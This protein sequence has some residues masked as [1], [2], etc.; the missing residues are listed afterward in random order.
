MAGT[1]ADAFST[2]PA[3]NGTFLTDLQTFLREE[4]ALRF[5]DQFSGM[6][7]SGGLHATAGSLTSPAFATV[8]Y[9]G[10]FRISQASATITYAD[11]ETTWVIA[12][13]DAA[14]NV[15]TFTRVGTSHYL[16]DASSSSRP[17]LPA[18]AV[19]LMEVTTAGGA[20]TT[21]KDLREMAPRPPIINVLD[22]GAV[23]DWNGATGTDNTTGLQ[24]AINAAA[25]R[26][27]AQAPA[28]VYFAPGRYRVTASLT[29]KSHMVLWM[30]EASL[31]SGVDITFLANTATI[32]NIRVL[33]GTFRGVG[34]T[35][36]A[37][38][39]I[40]LGGTSGTTTPATRFTLKDLSIFQEDYGIWL[41]DSHHGTVENIY[42]EGV[43][44][45][46]GHAIIFAG[47]DHL[48]IKNVLAKDYKGNLIF[49]HRTTG[50]AQNAYITVEGI[51]G[52][53]LAGSVT[54]IGI[55]VRN[56]QYA[57][58]DQVVLD[59]P[60]VA[61]V[62][63]QAE[64][65][66]TVNLRDIVLSNVVMRNVQQRGVLVHS[67]NRAGA[68]AR[69]TLDTITIFQAGVAAAVPSVDIVQTVGGKL[70]N[71][72]INDTQGTHAIDIQNGSHE[73]QLTN[74]HIENVDQTGIRIGNTA[75]CNRLT[76]SGI[77][78][79]DASQDAHNTDND[80]QITGSSTDIVLDGFNLQA[81]ATNKARAGIQTVAGTSRITL[82][83]G[84]TQDHATQG[85]DRND[86]GAGAPY[87]MDT[88][89]VN[90]TGSTDE[91]TMKTLTLPA[92]VM[93]TNRGMRVTAFGTLTG[94]TDTKTIRLKLGT[95]TL[96]TV[97]AAAGSTADWSIAAVLL[98]NASAA[99]QRVFVK[100]YEG[101]TVEVVD[102]ATTTETNAS[103]LTMTLTGQLGNAA[104]T[105]SV[106]GWLVEPL[107]RFFGTIMP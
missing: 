32:D 3:A 72:V 6:V 10:G 61:G 90:Q 106:T 31:E 81:T 62:Q 74:I 35:S 93:S 60:Y 40:Q 4:D 38:A 1:D 68:V 57:T 14:G 19:W 24:N 105:I 64:A 23:P 82:G 76:L 86:T 43:N 22:Y 102:V 101:T 9:C 78:V 103:A 77:F 15:G 107:N 67:S 11:A 70:A 54:A 51:T 29:L 52:I 47:C 97:S 85:I 27:S 36:N 46:N 45:T 98:W 44:S 88:T 2:L 96:A 18:N 37:R 25:D 65:G 28:L 12:H 20:I 48:H 69:V 39:A 92:N 53:A 58:I 100:A 95:T 8:A 75:A 99:S 91:T 83:Q 56:L 104:D 89:Q 73:W 16:I 66:D 30:Y 79:K 34:A 80:I 71:C 7:V 59:S 94:V 41:N 42:F 87:T 49:A 5:N 33:G 21:V 17:A 84:I 26:G 50:D 55:N 63:I 13:V